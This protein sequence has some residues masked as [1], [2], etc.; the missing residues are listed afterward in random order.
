MTVIPFADVPYIEPEEIPGFF[1]VYFIT[2]LEVPDKAFIGASV[3]YMGAGTGHAR[4]AHEDTVEVAYV[5]EGRGCESFWDEEENE[6]AVDFGPG[7]LA[8]IPPKKE[9]QTISVS[10]DEDPLTMYIF[11]ARQT[12]ASARIRLAPGGTFRYTAP[13]ESILFSVTGVGRLTDCRET[14][15]LEKYTHVELARGES[16]QISGEGEFLLFALT[17]EGFPEEAEPLSGIS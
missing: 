7:M 3:L 15:T 5:L 10:S 13:S 17:H 2:E 11:T 16:V 9:H 4:H 1:R 6:S 12:P 8:V 14:R